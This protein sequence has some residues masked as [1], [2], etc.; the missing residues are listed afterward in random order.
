MIDKTSFNRLKEILF[1]KYNED[2]EEMGYACLIIRERP[3]NKGKMGILEDVWIHPPFRRQGIA[4][5]LI[6]KVIEEGKKLG[7]YKIVLCC[8]DENIGLYEQCKF[9]IYQ[10]AMRLN[11][12]G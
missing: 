7:L 9:N 12:N 10:N 2:N 11:I 4:T 8:S 3:E 6:K 5:E 1:T